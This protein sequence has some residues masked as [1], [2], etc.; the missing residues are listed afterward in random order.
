MLEN[1]GKYGEITKQAAEAG[2]VD[3][4]ISVI[5]K[6][7]Y[8]KGAAVGVVVGGAAV[9]GVAAAVVAYRSRKA[10]A[11]AAKKELRT[12]ARDAE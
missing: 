2:G 4:L 1:L 9:S 7:A 12:T 11:E 3:K 6:A 10:R 8:T 5:E